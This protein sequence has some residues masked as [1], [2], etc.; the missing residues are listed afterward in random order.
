MIE[1]EAAQTVEDASQGAVNQGSNSKSQKLQFFE[2]EDKNHALSQILSREG[3]FQEA[4]ISQTKEAGETL[5]QEAVELHFLQSEAVAE[6]P[7]DYTFFLQ[8]NEQKLEGA[9]VVPTETLY[10][11]VHLSCA[12][13]IPGPNVTPK[14]PV[15]MSKID[16]K[17]FS[18]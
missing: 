11:W 10:E 13:W 18:L 12:M 5:P 2:R 9:D 7:E 1:S 14:T 8:R 3:N 15:R 4:L 16:M 6:I 17:R